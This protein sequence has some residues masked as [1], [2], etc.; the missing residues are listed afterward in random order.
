[1]KDVTTELDARY[2]HRREAY[3]KD[4]PLQRV[5]RDSYCSTLQ[6]LFNMQQQITLNGI[7]KLIA[8]TNRGDQ[9]LWF[10]L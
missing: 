9:S 2:N 8:I 1:M 3:K 5:P 4:S 7:I 10:D 6:Q